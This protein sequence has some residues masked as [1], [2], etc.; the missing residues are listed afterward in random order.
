MK[1]RFFFF[2]LGILWGQLASAREINV[3]DNLKMI[4]SLI[5][6]CQF[7]KAQ[8]R[9]V[10]FIQVVTKER[11]EKEYRSFLL[12]LK[13]RQALIVDRK[14]GE[15][16]EAQK[17][18]LEIVNEAEIREL[19]N[20]SARILML[21]ALCYEKTGNYD[22][23]QQYLNWANEKIE[24]YN[25][26]ILKST[27]FIRMASYSRLTGAIDTAFAYASSAV[28]FAQKYNNEKDLTDAYLLLGFIASKRGDFDD[29]IINY[30][31]ILSYLK[32]INSTT[33]V[34]VSYNNIARAY[35]KKRDF[36][37][38]LTYNDSSFAFYNDVA[39]YYK[40]ILAQ[41]RSEVYD[42]LGSIDSA[43]HYFRMYHADW[44]L[45]RKEESMLHSK[46]MEEQFQ[47]DQ[48]EI[49]IKNKN[50]QV[51]FISCLLIII[52]IT[53]VLLVRKN[54]QINKQ[55]KTINKQLVE[56][57]KT[58]EQKQVLLSELQHRVKNNLQHVISILEIQKESVDFNNIDE[59]IRGNQNRIH[60]MALLHKKLNVAEAVNRVD[61]PRYIKELAEL[62]KESYTTPKRKIELYISCSLNTLSIE[63]A[64]PIGL[65]IVEL[66]SN[67]M[68]HA[69][70][71]RSKGQIRI[72]ISEDETVPK[73]R[74]AYTDNGTGFEFNSNKSKGLGIE[75]IHGLID[76]LHGKLETR[77][78]NG[79]ELIAY[80]K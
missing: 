29:A 56:L 68:K 79:F 47:S 70:D 69:F 18:L 67:S 20:L 13:F 36:Y 14:Q 33:T 32:K 9:T 21:L 80:F 35:L 17:I 55:N 65:V 71:K 74:L 42:S 6:Y 10:H 57:S 46:K 39:I 25:F 15:V 73:Y 38:A 52:A 50:Q 51:L 66:V 58:L 54:R 75:I 24:S 53:S 78:N 31:V 40:Y 11:Q 2:I 16:S 4:D 49:T 72:S 5:T 1:W 19:H 62:V 34:A 77:N 22:L 43:Y 63:K 3:A 28:T 60:S 7:E 64:L 8:D 44:E 61:L 41:V 59:L 37:T 26:E 48:K 76:Q 45:S 12:E 27:F 23:T 30:K